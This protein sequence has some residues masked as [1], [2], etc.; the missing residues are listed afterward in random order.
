MNAL[1]VAPFYTEFTV[2]LTLISPSVV[3]AELDPDVQAFFAPLLALEG[4]SVGE[5]EIVEVAV[6]R[7][8][9]SGVADVEKEEEWKIVKRQRKK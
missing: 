5:E 8:G 2:L 7:G 9:G 6:Q 4:G 1:F 3:F